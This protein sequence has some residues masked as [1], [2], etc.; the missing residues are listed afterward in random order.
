MGD[1][2]VDVAVLKTLLGN[3]KEKLAELYRGQSDFL[4]DWPNHVSKIAQLETRV[5]AVETSLKDYIDN[6]RYS[7]TTVISVLS[8]I[9]TLIL[10]WLEYRAHGG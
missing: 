10:A 5:G 9:A 4:K 3:L 2:K 8:L 6:Q 7:W 1:E